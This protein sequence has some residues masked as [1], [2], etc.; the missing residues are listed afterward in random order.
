MV[1]QAP[2]IIWP[3]ETG[4]DCITDCLT[5]NSRESLYFSNDISSWLKAH[6]C[7]YENFAIHP[8]SYKKQYHADLYYTTFHHLRYAHLR[9]AKCLFTNIQKQ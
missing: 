1:S 9:Y 6:Q 4:F 2:H 7:R 3:K 8:Y 5:D